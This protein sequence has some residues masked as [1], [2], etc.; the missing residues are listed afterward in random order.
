MA[1]AI[2]LHAAVAVQG[3]FPVLAGV[4]LELEPGQVCAVLGANGAGKT[5]LIRLLAGLMALE[6]GSGT[7]LGLDLA[8]QAP[9]IRRQVGMMGH[10][11]GLYD[12]L[13]AWENLEF[14]LKAARLDPT[15]AV[16]ALERVGIEGRLAKTPV[17]E[18]S[19]GQQ[20]RVAL[21]SLI[22]RR[23]RLWLLDE[24]HASLDTEARLLIGELIDEAAR[25][26][27]TVVATS[28]EPEMAIPLADL[29]ITMAGGVVVERASGTRAPGG[30]NDVA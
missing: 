1:P 19:A 15:T 3:R 23:P 5:S 11:L 28:H 20:R 12:E 24:P 2:S 30:P 17:G 27:A 14:A 9:A 22:A 18:L 13:L 29:V 4:E 7:V 21:A 8:S 6:R 10:G 16:S 25:A 26:G